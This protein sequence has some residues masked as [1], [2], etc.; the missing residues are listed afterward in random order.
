MKK[1]ACFAVFIV[2]IGIPM[3]CFASDSKP[4]N[5]TFVIVHGATGGGWDWKTVDAKLV[6]LSHDVYRATLTGLGEKHHLAKFD[7]NLTTHIDD[8]AN[9]II[10]E[11]LNNVV[12]VGHSYGGMVI[13]GVMDRMP[14]RIQHAVFLDAAVPDDGMSAQDVWGGLFSPDTKIENGLVYFPWLDDSAAPPKD[15]PHPHKSVT[16]KV[17]YDS[18]LAKSINATF[19]AFVPEGVTREQR[20]ED[21][22][23]KRAVAR[24]WTVR[25]FAGDHVIYREK[26]REIAE[27]LVESVGDT[28]SSED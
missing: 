10:Y 14:E 20:A 1:I 5:F 19:V 22:S 12:L 15:V 6:D 4:K 18:A 9:L 8:V 7:I 17:S 13:T 27:L 23:W 3:L 21:P 16:E 24:G 28:N 26:P 2:A 25:T 11:E